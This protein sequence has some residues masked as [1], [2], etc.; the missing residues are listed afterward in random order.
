MFFV[1]S[2]SLGGKQGFQIGSAMGRLPGAESLPPTNGLV[3]GKESRDSGA[4][5]YTR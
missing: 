2:P 4:A 1:F 3:R 5:R